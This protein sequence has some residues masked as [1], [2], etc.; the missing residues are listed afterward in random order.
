MIRRSPSLPLRIATRS[1][2]LAADRR[3]AAALEFA[4]VGPALVAILLSVAD[5]GV[6]VQ[7]SIRLEGAARAGAEYAASFPTDAAGIRAAVLDA[8]PGWTN[9]SVPTPTMWCECP[10]A[11]GAVGCGTTCQAGLKRY[12]SI[13]ASRPLARL[14][15]PAPSTV[16]GDVVLRIR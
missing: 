1:R 16:T 13:S 9:V 3:G 2:Q 14:L 15:L 5:L 11:G 8:L 12:I 10:G 7:Q 6:A 4:F